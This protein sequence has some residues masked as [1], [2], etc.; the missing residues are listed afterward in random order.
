MNNIFGKLFRGEQ[1]A[2]VGVNV[3]IDNGTLVRL[4]IAIL[5]VCV[6]TV[7]ITKY[8]KL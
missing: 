6:F 1:A 8:I 4:S 7:L 3:E 2:T 5:F